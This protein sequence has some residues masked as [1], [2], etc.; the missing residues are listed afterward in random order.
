MRE[1]IRGKNVNGW[2]IT[3]DMGRYGTN[4]PYRASW[5]FF[6]V[7]GNLAEDAIYPVAKTDGD[8]KLLDGASKYELRFAKSEMPPA[9]AFWSLTSYDADSYLVPNSINRYAL[10]DRSRMKFGDDGSLTIYIQNE[11][12]SADRQ[13][14]WLPAPKQGGMLLALRLYAPRKEVADGIWAPPPVRRVQ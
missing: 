6:G 14:N 4:Y 13:A 1:T 10:G 9:G 2:E 11:P 3:L 7:G 12:P 5:T 8:G